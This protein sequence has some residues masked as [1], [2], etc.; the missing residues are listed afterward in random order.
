MLLVF[1][2]VLFVG[3]LVGIPI[4]FSM[5][6][7]NLVMLNIMDFPVVSYA[8]KLFAGMDSFALL[9]VPFYMFVGE[10][11][12]KGG[13]AKRLMVFSDALVGHIRGGL[14][15]VNILSSMF[16]GGISGSAI[17][18]TAAIGGLLIPLMEEEG[19]DPAYSAAVTASSSVIGIII[20]P[21]IPF[22]LYGV[23]TSTSISRMF[24]GGIIPGILTGITLMFITYI[25]VGKHKVDKNNGVKKHFVLKN[26]F[27][28]LGEAWSA[29]IVPLIIIVGILAGVFTATE[30]GV[31]AAIVALGLG[32]FVFKE[33]KLKDLPEILFNTSKTT[34]S[35]LFL[36]GNASVTAYL[37]TLAQVPQELAMV[38]S[39][40]S[41]NPIVI[42]IV[43]NILLLLVGFVMDITPAILILGPVLLPVMTKFGVDPVFWGVI[44]CINL[45]I[46]LITPPVGTVLFVASGVA[47]VKMEALVKAIIPF[48]IGMV[49]LLVVLIIFPQLITFLP[50]LLL[51]LK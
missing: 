35:V 31:V 47:N 38:F 10:V 26:V 5:A 44:M 42:I 23:T 17:A 45:G 34:A 16:F 39:T 20:P 37:L 8:Q 6:L 50:D 14:G 28:S 2:G 24:I 36:C 33:L 12:N 4:V 51:P 21:S 43:A 3:I 49:G 40:L 30:A 13:I 32:L 29:L 22:I 48:F 18:D 1:L 41:D 11:M 27:S 7:A 46:G 15:H 19:Y 25:T 9:A